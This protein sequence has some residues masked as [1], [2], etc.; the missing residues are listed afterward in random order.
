MIEI[1]GVTIDMSSLPLPL[2]FLT[3]IIVIGLV[4]YLTVYLNLVQEHEALKGEHAVATTNLTNEVKALAE[5]Q[6]LL[7]SSVEDIKNDLNRI[8]NKT[9]ESI[10]SLSGEIDESFNNKIDK[11]NDDIEH[12]MT[13]MTNLVE[14][15]M[16]IITTN[17][18][19]NA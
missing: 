6:M 9:S 7:N 17:R 2:L 4:F 1:A 18:Q 19:S 10:R 13:D 16:L 12:S 11:L 15:L 8:A 5:K 3:I 14:R